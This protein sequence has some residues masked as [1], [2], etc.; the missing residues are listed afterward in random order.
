MGCAWVCCVTTAL[1]V[2][3]APRIITAVAAVPAWDWM[4]TVPSR[5]MGSA[6]AFHENEAAVSEAPAT[7]TTMVAC[8]DTADTTAAGPNT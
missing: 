5:N 7:N 2:V 4:S 6:V 1:M 3:A 8:T